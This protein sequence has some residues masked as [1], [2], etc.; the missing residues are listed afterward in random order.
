MYCA[1]NMLFLKAITCSGLPILKN[2]K[3][4]GSVTHVSAN[5]PTRVYRIFIENML[6]QQDKKWQA[7]FAPT[8]I[9]LQC[10]FHLFPDL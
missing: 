1:Y 3:L 6:K 10:G 7:Y 9:V 8:T 5:A 2:G 4:D